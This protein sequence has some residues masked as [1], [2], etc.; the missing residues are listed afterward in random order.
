MMLESL[1]SK[2]FAVSNAAYLEHWAT[3]L[4]LSTIYKLRNLK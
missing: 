3:G 2:V 1:V 4:Y